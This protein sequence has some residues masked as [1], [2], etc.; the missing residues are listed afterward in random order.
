MW[1]LLVLEVG[2]QCSD[3]CG[4]T[5]GGWS[6]EQRAR[7]ETLKCLGE[8]ARCLERELRPYD[9]SGQFVVDLGDCPRVADAVDSEA[10]V[11]RE[12]SSSA[13]RALAFGC[14]TPLDAV[15]LRARRTLGGLHGITPSI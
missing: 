5:S 7:G 2:A 11:A 6:G 14:L 12:H 13:L 4:I 10:R 9:W 8:L 3:F 1:R 15:Q